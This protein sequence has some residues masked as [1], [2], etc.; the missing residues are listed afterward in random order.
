MLDHVLVIYKK[1]LHQIYFE[2][3]RLQIAK[4]R[5]RFSEADRG[6][7]LA[8]HQAHHRSLDQVTAALTAAGIRHRLVYRARHVD[9]SPYSLILSVGGDGTFIRSRPPGRRPADLGVN[10]DPERSVGVFCAV[11]GDGFADFLARLAAKG[12]RYRRYT[13]LEMQI[14]SERHPYRGAQRRAGRPPLPGGDE[15]LPVAPGRAGRGAALLG[16]LDRHRRG[17]Q[18]RHPFRRRPHSAA[19]L[20]TAGIPAAGAF[21]KRPAIPA[22]GC[23]AG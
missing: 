20:E 3:R 9:Y 4:S 1:S 5:N 15:P 18:R 19:R 11:T 10:S 12:A 17:L 6:R 22:T 13:R 7:F 23:A 2:E 21:P 8:S 16:P 14:N